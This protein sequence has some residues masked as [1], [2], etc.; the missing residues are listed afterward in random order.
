MSGREWKPG[1]VAMV[2]ARDLTQPAVRGASTGWYWPGD[3]LGDRDVTDVRPLVVIDPEDGDAVERM[4]SLYYAKRAAGL[5]QL[6]AM[7][8]A[9]RE[10]A[11]PAPPK[12]EEPTGLGAVVEDERGTRW[13][14]SPDTDYPDAPWASAEFY[15]RPWSEINAVRK[16]SEGVPS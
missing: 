9:L 15:P 2:T 8:A 11:N 6:T 3:F 16:L 10:F 13:V 4:N 1:D 7:Q 5:A 14:R 12:P